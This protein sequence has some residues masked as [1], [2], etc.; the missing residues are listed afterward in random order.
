M[1]IIATA[2]NAVIINP[3]LS[4]IIQMVSFWPVFNR[5]SAFY[6]MNDVPID[7]M[8]VCNST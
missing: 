5:K 8:H 6:I 4:V 7:L 2:F 3:V 1:A